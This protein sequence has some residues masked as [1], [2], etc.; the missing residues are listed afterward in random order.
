[1]ARDLGLEVIATAAPSSRQHLLDLGVTTVIDRTADRFEDKLSDMDL[2]IDLA[3]GDA[4]ER[5][6]TVLRQGGALVSAA[7]FDIA[8]P[9]ADGRRG[10]PFRMQPDSDR[11]AVLADAV[12]EGRLAITIDRTVP[13]NAI[14]A[15]IERN[16]TGHGPGKIVADFTL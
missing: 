6:W 5:S 14:P 13:F 3:G 2:V 11:L 4:P 9:R 15:A 12:A 10:I 8:A 1:M 7:R 16:R